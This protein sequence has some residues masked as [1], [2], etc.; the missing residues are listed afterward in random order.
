[1]PLPRTPYLAA[2]AGAASLMTLATPA[3]AT[4]AVRVERVSVSSAGGQGDA[5][6]GVAGARAAAIS[7]S[8]R[9]VAFT[10]AAANLVAGDGNGR[11]DV[12]LRDRR[13]G[14]TV[15]VSGERGGLE[16]SLSRGGGTL[17]FATLDAR[18]RRSL[19]LY[20]RGGGATR[21]LRISKRGVPAR[22][23]RILSAVLAPDGRHVGILAGRRDVGQDVRDVVL[24]VLDR[25]TGRS[26]LVLSRPYND[27][28]AAFSLSADGRRVAFSTGARL[29][30]GDRNGTGDVYVADTKTGKRRRVSLGARRFSSDPSIS[31]D[32]RFVAFAS[33]DDVWR[34][35]LVRRRTVRVRAGSGTASSPSISADGRRVAFQL[36]PSSVIADGQGPIGEVWVRDLHA[37]RSVL[38]SPGGEGRSGFPALAAGGKVV[39]F[40]SAATALVPADTN[41]VP[42]VFVALGL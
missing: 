2:L 29:T 39:A 26:R 37:R 30:R 27:I 11:P 41:G 10:S 17:L 28:G 24:S 5:E 36:S 3:S 38:A 31:A 20:D 34:R 40:G 42:D 25:R 6:S 18:R 35:D 13:G 4:A 19:W 15:R 7:A 12:F 32:G 16:P 1:M 22:D 33:G 23:L 21:R 14:T 8:G 9:F